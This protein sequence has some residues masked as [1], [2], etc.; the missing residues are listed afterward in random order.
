MMRRYKVNLRK[1]VIVL[2]VLLYSTNSFAQQK[3][4]DVTKVITSEVNKKEIYDEIEAL[5]TLQANENVELTSSITENIVEVNFTD[6][7]RV[8]KGDV[9]VQMDIT[10]ELAE[11]EEEEFTLKEAETQLKRLKPLVK[12]GA[13]SKSDLDSQ[14]RDLNTSTAR[15]KIIESRINR[16]VIKAPFDGVLGMKNIS[17]GSLAQPGTLIT[18]IDDDSIM[19]LDFSIPE[20]YLSNLEIGMKV[21]VKSN[22]YPNE[23]FEG[24]VKSINS[25]VDSVT[26]AVMVRAEFPNENLKLKAGML[27]SISLASNPRQALIIPEESLIM[28]AEKAYVFK[29]IENDG[30]KF[31][32]KTTVKIGNGK[33]GNLE[34]ISGLSDGDEVVTHGIVKIRDGSEIEVLAQE[35]NNETLTELLQKSKN[36]LGAK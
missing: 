24:L 4:D 6:N 32:K 12:K 22:T 20:I 7:Q 28:E 16:K 9:I 13:A 35:R 34:V 33:N 14:Q 1:C 15:I 31:T 8:K 10:E 18:T 19:L 11:K 29:I 3:P 17:V 26:R 23:K 5:G 21:I 30:K 2:V 25:R 27:M 36:K